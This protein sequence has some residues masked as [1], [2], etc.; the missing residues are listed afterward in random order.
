MSLTTNEDNKPLEDWLSEY[1]KPKTRQQAQ[2]FF[3]VYLQWQKK[4]PKQLKDEFNNVQVKSQILQFQ[5]YL[6]NDYKNKFGNALKNNS[7][8]QYIT[9]VR[10]FYSSQVEPIRGLKGKIIDVEMAKGEHTFSIEDLRAM[11]A[12]GDLK[13]K[14]IIATGVSLGWEI[15]AILDLDRD[16]IEKLVLRAKSQNIEF[17]G[18]DW[19]RAKT[20]SAQYGIL[21][22]MALFALEQYLAKLNKESPNQTK[23]FD[24][25]EVAINNILKKL[26][27]DAN[28]AL[29]GSIRYHLLRKFLMSAL[30]DAG[31]NAFE[32][33]L[34][35]GK[36]IPISDATYLQTLKKSS[37]E[38]Y[39]QAYPTHLSLTQNINGVAKY[40]ILTDLVVKM[41][42]ANQAVN[43]YLKTQGMLEHMPQ[44]IIDQL[45][46]VY[47]FAKIMDKENGKQ[48]I[49]DNGAKMS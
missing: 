20:G 18:F 9:C 40:N 37:L 33:K 27:S 4:T 36:T 29:I 48:D 15:S 49:K 19:Q 17:I 31:L 21:N 6:V 43:D 47:E 25:T 14:A 30:S 1:S 16:Y 35:L 5:N 8:R 24:L 2:D 3:N 11:Y 13:Q 26:A 46:S 42:K 10:A 23:L 34:I 32:I 12:V 7:A 44:P 45:N 39:K 38:K 41:A 22:P 28:L